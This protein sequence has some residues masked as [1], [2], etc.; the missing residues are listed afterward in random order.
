MKSTKSTPSLITK[1][2]HKMNPLTLEPGGYNMKLELSNGDVNYAR[3]VKSPYQYIVAT[4][5]E[6]LLEGVVNIS[7]ATVAATGELIYENGKFASKFNGR[8]K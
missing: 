3:N 8:G 1:N 6:L 4:V 7:K 2:G 5:T